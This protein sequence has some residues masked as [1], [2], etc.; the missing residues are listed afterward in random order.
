MVMLWMRSNGGENDNVTEVECYGGGQ[1]NGGSLFSCYRTGH[2]LLG[3]HGHVTE[4][5]SLMEGEW[6]VNG[7]VIM[8]RMVACYGA[9]F[10]W[11]V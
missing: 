6:S 5:A 2:V 4:L 8:G 9:Y 3:R 11:S 7:Q 1:F 10:K